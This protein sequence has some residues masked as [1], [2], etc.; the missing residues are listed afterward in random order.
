MEKFG[1][2]MIESH[3]S[4]HDDF[5]ISLPPVDRLVDDAVKFGALGARQTG[6][7]FRGCIVA[8]IVNEERQTWQDK[9][10]SH[11]PDAFHVC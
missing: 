7:G 11:H 1:H 2:L 3:A 4:Q 10:L 5:E 9:L 8:R 6:G